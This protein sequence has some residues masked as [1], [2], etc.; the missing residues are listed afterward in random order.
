MVC[1]TNYDN[2]Y[3]ANDAGHVNN[4]MEAY[5]VKELL[6]L[7]GAIR[8]ITI[9]IGIPVVS[10]FLVSRDSATSKLFDVWFI[11]LLILTV[12]ENMLHQF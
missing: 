5:I 9:I 3:K 10:V 11:A 2:R 12:T 7:I 8:L 6:T 1:N 4:K